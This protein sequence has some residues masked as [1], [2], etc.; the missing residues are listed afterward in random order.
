MAGRGDVSSRLGTAIRKLREERGISSRKLA[1]EVGISSPYMSD[2][3]RGWIETPGVDVLKK[4]A[5]ALNCSAP[6]LFA[7]ADSVPPE[8]LKAA[9]R[10]PEVFAGVAK[11]FSRMNRRDAEALA[12]KISEYAEGLRD[13][14]E[15]SGG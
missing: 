1:R 15:K 12:A 8:V 4:I 2:I 13:E 10:H 6:S 3:E 9:Q 11:A 14:D 7:L 5:K